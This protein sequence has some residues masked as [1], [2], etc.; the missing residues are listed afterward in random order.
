MTNPIAMKDADII[1]MSDGSVKKVIDKIKGQWKWRHR[2]PP[3]PF[4]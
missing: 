2:Q 1:R 3:F 4:L